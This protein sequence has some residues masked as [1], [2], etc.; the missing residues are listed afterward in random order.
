LNSTGYN[1]IDT[2]TFAFLFILIAILFYKIVLKRLKIKVDGRFSLAL[3]PWILLGSILRVLEDSGYFVTYFLISP[4][5]YITIF[6]LAFSSL[7]LA[8]FFWKKTKIPYHI[9][10]FTIGFILDGIFFTQLK[11]TFF[12]GIINVLL[13]DIVLLSLILILGNLSEITK[14]LYNKFTI[15]SQVY[16]A[17]STFISVQF[18][19][20]SEQHVLPNFLIPLL[21][22]NWFFFVIIKFLIALI[23]VYAIDIYI[24]NKNFGNWLKLLVIILGT[25]QGT[26]DMLML[27]VFGV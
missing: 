1:P 18:Y 11:I 24:E 22:G 17:S 9:Y 5:I 8:I 20:Y 21:G 14:S 25:A 16:D 6:V 12:E 15:F 23:L 2:L 19:G 27:G 7:L 13:L 10:F 26:R 3:L 4:L